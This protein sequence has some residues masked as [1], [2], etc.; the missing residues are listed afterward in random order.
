MWSE[1]QRKKKMLALK[2]ARKYIIDN[3]GCTS[4]KA[5]EIG[6][7]GFMELQRRKLAFWK[8]DDNGIVRWYVKSML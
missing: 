4:A 8:R 6:I 3:P 5:G 1:N 2:I 7:Y